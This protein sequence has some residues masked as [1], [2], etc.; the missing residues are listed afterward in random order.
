MTKKITESEIK[1]VAAANGVE[2]AVLR[3]II[4]VEA[5]GSGFL[6]D[7]TPTILFERHKFYEEL[8]KINFY[9]VRKRMQQLKPELCHRYVTPRGGYGKGSEQPQRMDDAINLIYE[10]APDADAETYAAV[11]ECGLKAASWGLSQILASNYA[12]AGFDTVQ[13]FINAMYESEKAQ[14]EATVNLMISWGLLEAM[15]DK[16]WHTIAKRWNGRAYAKHGYHTKL[17][18]SY[19]RYA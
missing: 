19:L 12:Q 18:N 5:R 9:T 13:D 7:G 14:L 17:A 15:R 2:Y 16:D 3:S 10:V 8:G 1:E 11:R 4:D 6:P